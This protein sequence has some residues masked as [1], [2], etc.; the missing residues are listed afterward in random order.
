MRC[1]WLP[2]YAKSSGC[3]ID[4]WSVSRRDLRIVTVV[5]FGLNCRVSRKFRLINRVVVEPLCTVWESLP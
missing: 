1:K 2:M 3:I 5:V 4:N